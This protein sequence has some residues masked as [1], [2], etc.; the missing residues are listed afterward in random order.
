MGIALSINVNKVAL[1]RNSRPGNYPHLPTYARRCIELGC[2]GIT[3]HPRPD[4]RH[5]RPSDTLDLAQL[6]KETPGVEFNIEGNPFELA[7]DSYPGL[8]TLVETCQPD[9]CTLVPDQTGQSTSDH[10]F[11][12]RRC[13]DELIP[14]IERL[15]SSGV[16]V[17]LFMDPDPEQIKLAAQCGANR[18]ELYTGPFAAAFAR[19]E[20]Q[21]EYKRHRVAAELAHSLGLGVN[22]G[23]DL[24]LE[25][26]NIYAGLPHLQ[27]VSIGHAFTVDCLYLGIESAM[28][29]YLAKLA[30]HRS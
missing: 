6:C 11:D 16:R 12:L 14:I 19:G 4:L 8:L 10:G 3:V 27:E 13:G 20:W 2:Q 21:A 28:G 15:H 29:A 26:L 9:Q 5:V 24:N 1:I 22:A 25:N 7:R 23:H 18:I 30:A 17:S